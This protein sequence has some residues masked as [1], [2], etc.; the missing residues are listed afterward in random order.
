MGKWPGYFWSTAR[1]PTLFGAVWAILLMLLL[2]GAA[3]A[4]CGHGRWHFHA[5]FALA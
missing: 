2:I 5:T 3:L 1:L 4:A